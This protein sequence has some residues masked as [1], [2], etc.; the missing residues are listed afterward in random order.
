MRARDVA[1]V[2]DRL[3]AKLRGS[4]H[5]P[6]GHDQFALTIRAVANDRRE[7]IWEDAWQERQIAGAVA[8]RAKPVADRGVQK[9]G[10]G[11]T[12][13]AKLSSRL[14][15]GAPERLTPGNPGD[16]AAG[17][18]PDGLIVGPFEAHNG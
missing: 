4:R 5:A 11:N 12:L 6:S 9:I 17:M 1:D 18:V 14:A 15:R 10:F 3:A 16:L 7:L 8:P 2:G 13:G